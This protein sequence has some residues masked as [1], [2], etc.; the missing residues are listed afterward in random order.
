MLQASPIGDYAN[1]DDDDDDVVFLLQE[2]F[3]LLERGAGVVG[4]TMAAGE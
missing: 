2:V 4:A 1:Y 3:P